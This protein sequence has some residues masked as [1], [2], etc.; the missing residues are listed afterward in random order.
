[1]KGF[2]L[3]L[4]GVGW[5]LRYRQTIVVA[6]FLAVLIFG[7]T[8]QFIYSKGDAHFAYFII[9]FSIITLH[10]LAPGIFLLTVLLIGIDAQ[11][12]IGGPIYQL[13]QDVVPVSY[14][15]LTLP[16]ILLV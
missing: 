4:L 16:T 5:S 6:T 14:T 10:W 1:M 3:K 2:S 11:I 8:Y 13:I 12:P 7:S 15:H 9:L